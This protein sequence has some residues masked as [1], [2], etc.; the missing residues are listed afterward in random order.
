MFRNVRTRWRYQPDGW[1]RMYLV[2]LS[3]ITQTSAAVTATSARREK[4]ALIAECLRAATP[5]EV[6]IVVGYL[7]GE[8]PQR[9]IGV[10]WAALREA[11][12][13]A[14]T[15][16]LTPL[17]VDAAFT[18]IGA[19]SG[20]GSVAERKRLIDELFGRATA[21]EQNFLLRLLSGELHQGALDGVMADAVA[22]AAGVPAADVR[23]AVMFRGSLGA[24]AGVAFESGVAGLAGFGIEVGRPIR[25]MLA[26]SAASVSDALAKISPAAVEW[27]LDGIRIQAHLVN[28]KMDLV[29]SKIENLVTGKIPDLA[30]GKIRLFTRT[31]DEITDR[32][33]EVVAALSALPVRSA[34]F[35]GELIALQDDGRPHPFQVTA[36][37]TARRGGTGP[38][39]PLSLFLFDVVHLDGEDLVDR[40]DA[41]RNAALTRI[42]PEALRMPRLVTASESDATA[43]FGEAVAAGHEGVV[44]K[45]LDTPY[46]AGRR[47]AGWI[48]VKPRHTLDLVVL[49]A[50]WGHGRRR[51]L[52][53]EPAPGG[54]RPRRLLRDAGQDVQ[55]PDR[56]VAEV[57]DRTTARVGGATRR[58]DRVSPARTRRG[59]RLRRCP[60]QPP[61]SRWDGAAV[62]PGSE[63]PAG[64]DRRRGRHDRHRPRHSGLDRLAPAPP[65]PPSHHARRPQSTDWLRPTLRDR[66]GRASTDWTSGTSPHERAVSPGKTGP[67][68]TDWT[69]QTPPSE[70]TVS[71]G[72]TNPFTA[73][74]TVA[75]AQHQRAVSP[76]ETIRA[77]AGWT[78][79]CGLDKPPR[80]GQAKGSADGPLRNRV[81]FCGVGGLPVEA[82]RAG[83]R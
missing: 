35:D 82:D 53:L 39:V 33:P 52:A 12:P 68:S 54:A 10:G 26:S 80:A 47:G 56:R 32:L 77:T 70:R 23:R 36:A 17:E 44:V 75:T 20:K 45:S 7:S 79:R 63:I 5:A 46:V 14:T 6:P 25:P 3:Q 71:L 15:P 31:L 50:E 40:P 60:A 16:T 1:G 19:V 64:Q 8:L 9:Q 28:D 42:V 72:E 55:G 11:R 21:D 34:V 74:W 73:D 76:S 48:K 61:L 13:P 83:P 4:I 2:Q 18:M 65:E 58:L 49:A 59:D 51:G 38:A 24:V 66:I 41:E 37:R 30:N 29:N 22:G 27:K 57:A 69:G 67:A 62:R 43:F 78:G 81:S